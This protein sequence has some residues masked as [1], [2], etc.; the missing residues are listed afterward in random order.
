GTE[1]ADTNYTIN[2]DPADDCTFEIVFNADFVKPLADNAE[3]VIT[4]SA[5]LDTDAEIAAETNDNTAWITYS[6]Q[7]SQPVTVTVATYMATVNKR[8]E[9]VNGDILD[10]AHFKLFDALTGGNEIEL[11]KVTTE[12]ETYYRPI[13]EGEEPEEIVVGTAVIKGLD[14]KT[15]Y[16]EETQ[17]P[18]GYNMLTA[19]EALN[20]G[21][22]T[23]INVVNNSGA[24]LPGT[25]GVG[26]TMFYVLGS[27]MMI[28]AAVLLVTKK[29]MANEQ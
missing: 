17:A 22:V 9:S 19:R 21:E 23:E 1:V 24:I 7:T 20:A 25:G 5:V 16:L 10:G 26:T 18:D 4:Y 29:K 13:V 3:I 11:I 2:F 28:G 27:V 15:Y 8:A 12:N 14:K 6:A